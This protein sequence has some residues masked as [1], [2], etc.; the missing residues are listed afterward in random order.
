MKH[1]Y[2]NKPVRRP[3]LT[4]VELLV[5]IS[6][7]TVVSS[8]FLV[9]Y[10]A[11]A[12]EASNM[13]TQS[14]IRKISEVLVSRMQEYENY[15]IQFARGT[16]NAFAIPVPGNA[17][18]ALPSTA[19]EYEP[20]GILLER[21]RLMLLREMIAQEMPDDYQDIKISAPIVKNYW[22]GRSWSQCQCRSSTNR[23]NGFG[24][25]EGGTLEGSI[26]SGQFELGVKNRTFVPGTSQLEK[27]AR[28]GVDEIQCRVPVLDRRGLDSQW[29]SGDRVVWQVGDRGHRW[30]W[31]FGISRF[32]PSADLLG[33][34]ADGFSRDDTI[35]SGLARPEFQ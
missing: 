27:R 24:V 2:F 22:T 32:I 11:A 15:P 10:R 28:E 18:P 3:G 5:S 26:E 21:L 17:V 34:L 19:D 9:A 7:I 23:R 20:K 1:A 31:T 16:G 4:L 14:T 35:S 29:E 25:P 12:T 33:A 30:R 6:L 13:R 8:M